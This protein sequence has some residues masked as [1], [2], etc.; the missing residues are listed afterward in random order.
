MWI[1]V[2]E[3]PKRRA[4]MFLF[5]LLL[6]FYK[7]W[8]RMTQRTT[9]KLKIG[10]FWVEEWKDYDGFKKLVF[11][12]CFVVWIVSKLSKAKKWT[13]I[14]VWC[15]F[16]FNTFGSFEVLKNFFCQLKQYCNYSKI[17]HKIDWPSAFYLLWFL[18]QKVWSDKNH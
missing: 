15:A 7:K 8:Q 17:E 18:L 4:H 6:V 13:R 2:V 1:E 14:A 16:D 12:S 11:S 10:H 5:L 9:S 3:A